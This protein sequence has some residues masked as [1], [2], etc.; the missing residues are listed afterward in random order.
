METCL[1]VPVS[2]CGGQE[3]R[4]RPWSVRARAFR[5][6]REE[7]GGWVDGWTGSSR[8]EEQDCGGGEDERRERQGQQDISMYE[9]ASPCCFLI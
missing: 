3:T 9:N 6:R 1:Y 5:E 7:T 2:M 8:G 4:K